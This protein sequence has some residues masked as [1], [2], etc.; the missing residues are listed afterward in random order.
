VEVGSR[1]EV[2]K[3]EQEMETTNKQ[4]KMKKKKKKNKNICRKMNRR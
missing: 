1:M 3:V 4:K 2:K